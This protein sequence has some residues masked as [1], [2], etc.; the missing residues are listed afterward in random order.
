MSVIIDI[1]KFFLAIVYGLLKLLP[2]KENRVL[3]FSRQDNDLSL[4]F[5][6]LKDELVKEIPGVEIKIICCRLGDDNK[7]YFKF[8][9]AMVKSM[10]YLATGKVCGLDAYWPTVSMLKHKKQ[11]TVIQMWHALGKI[12]KSGYQT[13]GKDFGR[14][15]M[16][17]KKLN[18]HKNYDIII[19][20]GKAWNPMYCQSFGT[21]ED[22][23]LNIGLPRIDYLLESAEA[24]KK[25]VLEKYPQLATKTLLLYAPTFRRNDS[26]A[27]SELLNSIDFDKYILVVKAHPNQ[28]ITWDN[29]NVYDCPEFKA[30]DLLSTCDYLITD[31][32]AIAIEG[33]IVNAKTYYY[34]YDYEEYREKNG[35]NIDI[36]Q[37][38][39]GC[40]FRNSQELMDAIEADNYPQEVLNSYRNRFLPEGLGQSTKMIAQTI[41]EVMASE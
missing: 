34:L 37:E 36:F 18:M 15:A 10:F 23:L 9:W 2:T 21:T 32:S 25:A 27:W 12:K 6:L 35:M 33:A 38:M 17:A 13:L 19:A 39:P 24:N 31:Y 7:N 8:A 1:F 26:N 20:G 16:M 30:V 22:K 3:F 29:E 4:D 28:Q 11:L 14:S 5:R 41:K 40:A